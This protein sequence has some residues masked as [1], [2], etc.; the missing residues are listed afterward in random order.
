MAKERRNKP[1]IKKISPLHFTFVGK[2]DKPYI[3]FRRGGVNAGTITKEINDKSIQSH[4]FIKFTNDKT[5]D[6]N[7]EKLKLIK[8]NFNNTV[9]PKF[10]SKPELIE[11]FNKLLL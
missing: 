11:E 3:S 6:E 7:I 10:I 4:Y 5:N 2:K 1:V 9:G 8:F